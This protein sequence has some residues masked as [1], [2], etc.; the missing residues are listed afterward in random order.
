MPRK[1]TGSWHIGVAAE[2][3]AAAQF[4]RLGYDVSVQYGANQPEYDLIVVREDHLMKVS[5]KGSQDG[6]WG[7]TQSFVRNADYHQAIEVWLERHSR[8]TVLCFVQFKDVRPDQ[9]PRLYLA[10]AA[11][12]AQMLRAAAKGR[13]D[14]ILYEHHTWGPRAAGAGTTERIPDEWRFSAER[15]DH[16]LRSST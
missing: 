2:A 15:I 4:A 9:M 10:R 14:T 12:V 16:L 1:N 11:D 7:L 6:S 8:N 3:I 13:G 5:V